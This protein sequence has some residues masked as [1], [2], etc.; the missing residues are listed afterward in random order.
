[1]SG[2]QMTDDELWQSL[3]QFL[4]QENLSRFT[5][6]GKMLERIKEREITF[7]LFAYL[8]G[9]GDGVFKVL[10]EH[11]LED[12]SY[13]V[14][15]I[16]I[17]LLRHFREYVERREKEKIKDK[18]DD[19]HSVTAGEIF[20]NDAGLSQKETQELAGI[21]RQEFQKIGRQNKGRNN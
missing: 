18:L 14:Q 4:T 21:F 9:D 13:E 6:K 5:G 12:K 19:L 16:L 2:K 17:E 1:M 10:R 20:T 3:E 15:D 7:L 11:D 8:K